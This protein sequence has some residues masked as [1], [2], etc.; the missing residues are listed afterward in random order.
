MKVVVVFSRTQWLPYSPRKYSWYSFLSE[1]EAAIVRPEGLC[2]WKIPMTPMGIEPTT[3]WLVA[4]CLKQLHHH[5][6][7]RLHVNYPLFLSNFNETWIFLTY[8]WKNPQM[9][10]FMKICLMGAE[11]F[12]VNRQTDMTKLTITS[13]SLWIWL[14]ENIT[15]YGKIL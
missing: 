12:H 11:M 6:S 14:K 5:V 2:Q 1:A 7:Q 9:L 3:F 13:Y 15:D 10:N 8:I 4:Q